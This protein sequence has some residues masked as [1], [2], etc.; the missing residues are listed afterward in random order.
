MNASNPN[1]TSQKALQQAYAKVLEKQGQSVS[2]DVPLG[3]GGSKVDLLTS[4]EMIQCRP[5]INR[6]SALSLKSQFDFYKRAYSAWQAVV[7][8]RSI[9]DSSAANL[10]AESGIKVV[11][12]PIE[13][14]LAKT[15]SDIALETKQ[16]KL[17]SQLVKIS[18]AT[19][20]DSEEGG[21]KVA[22]LCAI[23]FVFLVGFCGFALSTGQSSQ[24]SSKSSIQQWGA[25][26]WGRIC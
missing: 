5:E 6:Q 12:I 15:S 4:Q 17:S 18:P 21:G 8:T 2:V 22:A 11:V 19:I 26:Q 24:E 1:A 25:I 3:N 9:S 16:T 13:A 14:E 23:A 20:S 10:L 7:V